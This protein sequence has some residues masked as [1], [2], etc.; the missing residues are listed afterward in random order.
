MTG[1]RDVSRRHFIRLAGGAGITVAATAA[2]GPL[3]AAC[4]GGKKDTLKVGVMAPFT[5]VGGFIGTVVNN[6]LDAASRQINSTGGVSGRKVELLLRDTGGDHATTSRVYSELVGTKDLLGILWCG[7]I[8]FDQLLPQVRRDGVPLVA[9]FEDPMSVGQLYPDGGGGG[10]SVFQVSVPD[11][12]VKEALADYARLDRGYSSAAMLYDAGLDG[13]LDLPAASRQHF[14]Q[15]FGA[16]GISL[17]GVETFHT[18]DDKFEPQLQRLKATAPQ[19][20]YLDGLS[21]DTANIATA[22][23]AMGAGYVDT[24]TAKGPDWHP[25]VFGSYRGINQIW[26]DNGAEAAKVGSV[27]AWHLGGLIFLPSFTIGAW[28]QK[29]LGKRP[30]G[31]EELPADGLATILRGLK[32]AGTADRRRL[33]EGIETMGQV[34]FASLPFNFSPTKHSSARRDDLAILTLERLR[35]PAATEPPYDLGAEWREGAPFAAQAAATTLLVRPTLAANR[36]ARPDVFR[37]AIEKG[38]GTQCTKH[39]DGTLGKECRIH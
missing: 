24:P 37:D 2:S 7:A 21:D 1:P 18:G 12:Y 36:R 6:S 30:T 16:G 33:V 22:L 32:K 11:T 14:E 9:V 3:L 17:K 25:H 27:S 8:G 35:G 15:A 23:D 5:G 29:Y 26:A 34:Q 4:S 19:V 39:R 38:Y 28:M 31:G 13:T 20:L 10:R